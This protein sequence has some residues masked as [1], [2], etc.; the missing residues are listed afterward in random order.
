MTLLPA[1]LAA[2]LLLAACGDTDTG[3]VPEPEYPFAA[4]AVGT[5]TTFEAVTWNLKNFPLRNGETVD[6]VAQ[7][8]LA[9]DPDVVALQEIENVSAFR[10]LLEALPGWQG[11]RASSAYASINLAYLYK[12]E[13]VEAL[14]A[15]I[16]EIYT[17]LRSPFPRAPL[18]FE[19]R[20]DGREVVLINNHF[21]C[22]GDGV[23]EAGEP[24]DEEFRRYEASRLLAEYVE[25]VFRDRAVIILGDLNDRIDDR[26]A[27]N[28]F[29]PFLERPLQFRFADAEIA[30]GSAVEWS[31]AGSSYSHLDHILVTA[32]LFDDLDEDAARVLTVR[33]DQVLPGGLPTYRSLVSDHRPV[34][35]KLDL[36]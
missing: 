12:T 16:Y 19:L 18:V 33:V 32:E 8:I 1:A 29:R 25:D 36:D 31:W 13:A 28:V 27:D 15:G 34:L 6:L 9:I 14:P 30:V 5:D 4:L 3:M 24:G 7:A 21:K 26:L 35:L 2:A 17:D 10:A 20:A 22:C 11:H 23:L